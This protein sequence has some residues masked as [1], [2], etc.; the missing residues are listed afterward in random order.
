M[1]EPIQTVPQEQCIR[2]KIR[3]AAS[4][5]VQSAGLKPPLNLT[6]LK[7][8]TAQLVEKLGLGNQGVE[9]FAMIMLNNAVWETYFP[10]IA[11]NQRLLLLPFCLRKQPGCT[12][13]HDELGLIC[14]GCGQC[15]I[16]HLS[17]AA[18]A[19]DMP[20]L[21]AE[22]SSAVSEWVEHGDI[23]AVVGVSCLESLEKSFSA[24][25]RCA[26]PG[27][28]VPLLRDGCKDTVFDYE[29]LRRAMSVPQNETVHSFTYHLIRQTVNELFTPAGLE[30]FIPDNMLR[31]EAIHALS[32]H[33]K[34]YR[35]LIA[36]GCY[37]ALVP[38]QT[39]LPV[40]LK[41]IA[42]AVECF[43]KASLI[44]DDI[45]DS[46]DERYH[47]P[48][49]HKRI[50][51]AAALNLG[52]YLIGIGYKLFCHD[53][54]PQGKCA[55][56]SSEASLAHCELSLGQAREFEALQQ[57][58][59]RQE[60]CLE[61]YRLKTSPAFRVALFAGA[62]A[63]GR[64]HEFRELLQAFSDKLG[65]A[66]QLFDDLEDAEENPASIVDVLMKT[67]NWGREAAREEA[68]RMYHVQH[69]EI[70]EILEQLDDVPLK[71]F[72]YRLTG[73]VLKDV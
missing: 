26:V 9:H 3:Q 38:E 60:D 49:L 10:H 52:D 67:N 4:S 72:L 54:I 63:A 1:S 39:E 53:S 32:A 58:N 42:L 2:E 8:Y 73:K 25:L 43:H 65:V 46:D 34:H 45:E 40:Y 41:P 16:P 28:A 59:L 11:L 47:E 71:I 18:D 48:A 31:E 29:E 37:A 5:L 36:G 14:R 56:L 62:I 7:R 22:S 15:S 61:I 55:E 64:F 44:H 27:I 30:E 70:Y 66:Y 12:A 69:E 24:M 50:G 6:L 21:V 33:G 35:P 13:A 17:D 51:L 19:L 57:Q 23:Q 68:I 20:V